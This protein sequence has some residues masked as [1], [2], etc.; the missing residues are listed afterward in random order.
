MAEHRRYL[1][2]A[3]YRTHILYL[4]EMSRTLII[5]GY[6]GRFIRFFLS[7]NQKCLLE[8][9]CGKSTQYLLEGGWTHNG[10]LICMSEPRRTAT[11]Q[12]AQSIADETDVLLGKNKLVNGYVLTMFIQ[13]V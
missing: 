9:G 6:T 5:I 7:W 1:P 3:A 4:L 11:V 12:L 13:V 2:I 10:K 8:I